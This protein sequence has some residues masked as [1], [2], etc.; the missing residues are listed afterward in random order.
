VARLL[1]ERGV[2]VEEENDLPSSLRKVLAG[3]LEAYAELENMAADVIA[4]HGDEMRELVKLQPALR[5]VPYYLMLSKGFVA[6]EPALA[7]RI[8]SAIG[9]AM[10][11]PQYRE[12]ERKYGV[13]P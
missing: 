11:S 2:R 10:R 8:W 3:R 7:E 12:L 4:R 1:R 6:R 13:T 9:E 5:T